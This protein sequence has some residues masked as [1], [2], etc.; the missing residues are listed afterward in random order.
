MTGSGAFILEKNSKDSGQRCDRRDE[1]LVNVDASTPAAKKAYTLQTV[2]CGWD[3]AKSL[4]FKLNK[5]E[6]LN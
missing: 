6:K 1:D 3:A 4:K 5:V 2:Y